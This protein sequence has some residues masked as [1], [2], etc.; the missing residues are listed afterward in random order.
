[1]PLPVEPWSEL[2]RLSDAARREIPFNLAPEA[3]ARAALAE[4]LG[5]SSLKKLRF[6]GVMIPEG[7]RD[8][9]LEA[10]LGATAVQPCVVTLAPVTTRI[11]EAVAR[12]YAAEQPSFEEGSEVEMPQDESVDPLP[13][14][15]DL[16]AVMAE[17]LALALPDWPR[18]AGVEAGDALAAPEGAE[19]LTDEAAKPL[20][21]LKR[22]LQERGG[23]SD[24]G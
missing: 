6:S 10:R 23:G 22:L 3:E 9:R 4:R 11:D 19:P 24:D 12:R 14:M 2:V 5:A 7:A 16:G 21:G 13:A 20:A 17:A 1:M 18:A 15:L 8:W